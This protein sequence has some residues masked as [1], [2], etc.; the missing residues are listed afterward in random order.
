MPENTDRTRRH[1][2]RAAFRSAAAATVLMV[3]LALVLLGLRYSM[4]IG[5]LPG[6]VLLILALLQLG[7]VVPVWM[8]LNARLKEIEGGEENDAA[9]Y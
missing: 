2:R 6:A 3:L 4:R 7:A 9:Q 5:G 8:A 1:R